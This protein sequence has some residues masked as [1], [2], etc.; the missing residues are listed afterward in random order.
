MFSLTSMSRLVTSSATRC[1][2]WLK[3]ESDSSIVPR[4]LFHAFLL[5]TLSLTS[6]SIS[7]LRFGR[8]SWVERITVSRLDLPAQMN[9]HIQSPQFI[10]ARPIVLPLKPGLI[11]RP[12][13][14]IARLGILMR[15]A[16]SQHTGS[17]I[18]RCGQGALAVCV[19]ACCWVGRVAGL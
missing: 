13:P 19:D 4:D 18:L 14:L 5:S 10:L 16:A 2:S 11:L 6:P 15:A 12:T 9:N 3:G 8:D 1:H 7:S 17:Y